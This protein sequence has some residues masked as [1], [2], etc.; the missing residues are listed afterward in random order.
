MILHDPDSVARQLQLLAERWSWESVETLCDV[1]V[2]AHM[3]GWAEEVHKLV[4]ALEQGSNS[5]AAV[6]R[7]LLA[8]H[9]AGILAVHHRMLYSTENT[10]WDLVADRMGEPWATAQARALG[11]Y[12]ESLD[13]S[14]RAALE[15]Y[16]ITV[17]E[18]RSLL[19][20]HQRAVVDHAVALAA[21]A[22]RA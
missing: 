22:M 6:Q 18:V 17:T 1:W 5:S 19:D 2:A 13:D 4:A 14:C 10:L 15:L 12:A 21:G 16:V 20:R 8:L 7:S 3:T 9:L 11:E